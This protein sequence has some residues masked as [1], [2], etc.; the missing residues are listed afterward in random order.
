MSFEAVAGA[1][2]LRVG[3]SSQKLVLILVANYADEEHTAWPA[4]TTL[5][6]QACMDVS[7]VGR[8]LTALEDDGHIKRERRHRDDGQ[9]T[10]DRIYLTFMGAEPP[11]PPNNLPGSGE[12]GLPNNLRGEGNVGVTNLQGMVREESITLEARD[13]LSRPAG[14]PVADSSKGERRVPTKPTGK[15]LALANKIL[16]AA[17][18]TARARSANDPAKVW[19]AL[20]EVVAGGDS[21]E[22][23][24]AAMVGYYQTPD[25]QKQ[26]GRWAAAPHTMIK[27][28]RWRNWI[29]RRAPHAVDLEPAVAAEAALVTWE[30]YSY[31]A[32]AGAYVGEG[33]GTY[34]NPG[35]RRQVQ[36]AEGW[37]ELGSWS[38]A[39]MGPPPTDLGCRLWPSVYKHFNIAKPGA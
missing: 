3:N 4:Q 26:G 25:C 34:E 38:V 28:G 37:N 23:C 6:E 15:L 19:Y 33:P 17:P 31:A 24:T 30:G 39:K 1:V 12:G 9:R 22:T 13:T 7:T 32:P 2:R 14:Q 27:D 16:D 11:P 8:A 5:A 18:P 35:I 20:Q 10:S 21:A 29:G 36:W